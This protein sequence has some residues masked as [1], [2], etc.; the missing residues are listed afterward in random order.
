MSKLMDFWERLFRQPVFSSSP[1]RVFLVL[2]VISIVL[3]G[4]WLFTYASTPELVSLTD[5]PLSSSQLSQAVSCL[6]Q[7]QQTFQIRGSYI[8]VE[9]A[10]Q[11]EL[12]ARMDFLSEIPEAQAPSQGDL[13][14]GSIFLSE[15]ERQQRWKLCREQALA[16]Q[17]RNFKGLRA[18]R[19]FLASPTKTGFGSVSTAPTASVV[20]WTDD[21]QPLDPDLAQAIR[22]TIVG[23]ISGLTPANVHVIDAA[24]GYY[25]PTVSSDDTHSAAI[26]SHLPNLRRRAESL[27]G[28]WEQKISNK[29]SYIP[30]L[31]VSVHI[32]PQSLWTA[33]QKTDADTP[34]PDIAVSV[35]IPRS[36]LLNLSS[37]PS[38]PIAQP[39][40]TEFQAITAE[41]I[42]K[43]TALVKAI[44]GRPTSSFVHVDWYYDS[45]PA[46]TLASTDATDSV[47]ATAPAPISRWLQPAYISAAIAMISLL[48]LLAIFVRRLTGTNRRQRAIALSRLDAERHYL[49]YT[50]AQQSTQQSGFT[51]ESSPYLGPAGTEVSAFEEL[52]KLDDATMR[53]LLARTEAQIVALALRTASDKL[54]RKILADLPCERRQDVHDHPDF[55]GPVRL[56]DIE[57]AQQ[58]LV[59]LLEISEPAEE[60]LVTSA[61]ESAT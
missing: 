48:T 22:Q 26:I 33:S 52:L 45:I 54:R 37:Q 30:D 44:I 18:A 31:F 23:T 40:D 57:A 27:E 53:G 16:A 19:V 41:Q 6:T 14:K 46:A 7:W 13:L 12:L 39:T 17:I 50:P 55:L 1:R 32:D 5:Q 28:Q 36:Y 20:V 61:S 56:S 58:E 15:T 47:H 49:A 59:D 29:L 11:K 3:T 60:Q 9:P 2:A 42:A 51:P 25:L 38:D 10:R 24:A 4:Y 43:I 34:Q 21:D 8:L 35:N